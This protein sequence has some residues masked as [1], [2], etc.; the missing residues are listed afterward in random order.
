MRG[1]K[2]LQ[3]FLSSLYCILILRNSRGVVLSNLRNAWCNPGMYSAS[4]A[5]CSALEI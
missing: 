3:N 4:N 5:R 2:P 1:Y